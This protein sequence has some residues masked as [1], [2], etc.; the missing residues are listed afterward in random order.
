MSQYKVPIENPKPDIDRF[1]KAMKGDIIPDKPP[2][3]EYLIDNA[4]MKPIL[5]EMI[6]R[7]WIETSDKTE[8]MGGQMDFSKENR[9]KIDAWLDNQIAFWYHMGYDYIRME[10]S[11]ELPAISMPVD[12]TAKGIIKQNRVWQD[13]HVGVIRTIEDFEK[14]KWPRITEEDFYIHNYISSHLPDG[15]GFITCHAGGVYEHLSR[16]M[17]YEGLCFALIDNPE[18]FSLMIDKLGNIIFDYTKQLLS[19]ENISAIFQGEDFGYNNQTL[20]SPQDIRKYFLP[21]HKKYAE[22]CHQSNKLYFLHS[23]GKI[24][25]IMEDLIN[26]VKIDGKHS[27]KDD[28]APVIEAKKLY[29]Q[30][31]ALL[32][33]VD[34]DKLTRL[35][36]ADLRKYVRNIIDKCAPGGRFAVGSG[37]SIA[38]YIPIENYLTLMDEALR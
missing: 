7:P 34:I 24:D 38:S 26:D 11:L 19:I 5:E 37:N 25:L 23:C 22:L 2:V 9:E 8:Y 13:E 15:M 17:S 36:P 16:L 21:W 4:L 12:D 1:I 10:A 6:G 29:G 35:E 31:I 32:G 30:R 20:I 18:L 14:Y 33:G 28:S 3:A 27:F